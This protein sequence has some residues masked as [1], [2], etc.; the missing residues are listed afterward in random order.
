MKKNERIKKLQMKN[1]L[2]TIYACFFFARKHCFERKIVV[3]SRSLEGVFLGV[4]ENSRFF[5]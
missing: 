3:S 1:P 4:H 5:S 2:A